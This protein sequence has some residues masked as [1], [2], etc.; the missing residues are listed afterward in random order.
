[1]DMGIR[2]FNVY[3]DLKHDRVHALDHMP[4]GCGIEFTWKYSQ[5]IPGM[6]P[7][8]SLSAKK[9]SSDLL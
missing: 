6:S 1:M 7:V 2:K 9:Y 3:Q 8:M 4:H 5:Q